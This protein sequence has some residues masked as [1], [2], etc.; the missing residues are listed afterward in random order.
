LLIAQ[1]DNRLVLSDVKLVLLEA[2]DPDTTITVLSRLGLADE[3][4][5]ASRW[6]TSTAL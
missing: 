2:L 6:P 1:C 4:S 5:H 3:G